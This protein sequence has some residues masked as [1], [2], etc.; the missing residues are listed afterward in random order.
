MEPEQTE[1]VD[2]MF[3]A[4]EAAV[5]SQVGELAMSI[6]FEDDALSTMDREL[7]NR[8]QKLDESKVQL[9]EILIQAG[10]QSVKLE[11]GL[12]PKVVHKRKYYKQAGVTDELLF[13]WLKMCKLS[14][15]I[16][17]TVHF[18][19]LQA[20]LK[21]HEQGGNDIPKDIFNVT[22]YNTVTL[23]GKSKFLAAKGRANDSQS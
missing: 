7:K 10:L 6:A 2:K 8:K 13:S 11:D 14:D 23:Y 3:T 12:S 17:P 20:T 9:A 15:I 19:T 21:A 18:G 4:D 5:A 22:D 1:T 16:K